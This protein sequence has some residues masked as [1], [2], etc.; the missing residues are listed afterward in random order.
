MRRA[1]AARRR[2]RTPAPPT[3]RGSS[4]GRLEIGLE[5]VDRDSD[6]RVGV[7]APQLRAGEADR[8]EPLRVLTGAAGVRV[9]EDLA[10]VERHDRAGAP[11]RVAGQARVGRR[12][13][14]AR[15]DAIAGG[16]PGGT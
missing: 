2:A 12:V 16:E 1:R 9:R 14:V 5:R 3:A 15:A 13:E 8:V 11:A 4:R 10:A 7:R 6:G